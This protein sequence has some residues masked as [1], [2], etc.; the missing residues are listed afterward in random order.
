MNIVEWQLKHHVG[1]DAM[2][3]LKELWLAGTDQHETKVIGNESAV[4][5]ACRV[6]ACETG[7]RLWRNNVGAGRLENG[8]F[9]RWGLCN[10]SKAMNGRIKSSDLIGIKPVVITQNMVGDTIGQFWAVETKHPKWRYSEQN[11]AQLTFLEI[12]T[13]LGGHSEFNNTGVLQ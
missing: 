5:H 1:D 11:V 7:G 3:D 2:A 4:Q 9:M 6:S 10:E 8:Q 13:A 12:V